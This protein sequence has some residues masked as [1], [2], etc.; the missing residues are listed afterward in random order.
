MAVQEAVSS[1]VRGYEPHDGEPYVADDIRT[2]HVRLW[3][4]DRMDFESSSLSLVADDSHIEEF[5]T[6]RSQRG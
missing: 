3:I 2:G 1:S 4:Y 6:H 5:V